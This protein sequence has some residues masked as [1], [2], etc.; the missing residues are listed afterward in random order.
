MLPGTI[1]SKDEEMSM[2]SYAEWVEIYTLMCQS[3][4]YRL[5]CNTDFF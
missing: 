2:N 4:T 1:Y 5:T 3:V